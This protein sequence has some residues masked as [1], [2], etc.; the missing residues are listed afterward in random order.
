LGK[1]LVQHVHDSARTTINN[2]MYF[3]LNNSQ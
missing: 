1:A 2:C 3:N